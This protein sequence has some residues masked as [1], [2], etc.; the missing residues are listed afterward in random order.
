MSTAAVPPSLTF[1]E[2]HDRLGNVPLE[3]IRMQPP[4]G[5]ATVADVLEIERRENRICE[6]VD[7]VLVE[8][9]MG[10]QESRIALILAFALE[11]FVKE[12]DLGVV[13]GPDGMIRLPENLV[14]VPDVAFAFWERFEG[15]EI[16]DEGAPEIVP[17]L[18]VEVLSKGNTPLE[19]AR[20]LREYFRAGVRLVWF[21]DPV[22]RSVTVY[23]GPSRSKTIPEDGTL[24]GGKVLPGFELPVQKLFARM[25]RKNRGK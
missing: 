6:L 11:A 19:M 10:Y 2:L 15:G 3:R 17:D 13:T 23:T 20:K 16:P 12:D 4:P 1:A 18:A 22:G 9:V 24:D 14:R 25:K 5:L 21:V 7:G 8:K